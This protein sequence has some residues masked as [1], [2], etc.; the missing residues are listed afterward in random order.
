MYFTQTLNVLLEMLQWLGHVRYSKQGQSKLEKP[1]QPLLRV[2]YKLGQIAVTHNGNLT[3]AKIIRV[4]RDAG[5][6]V[7]K[8][9]NKKVIIKMM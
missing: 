4:I 9:K 7:H 6:A 5:S 3:N 8:A 2:R 1:A